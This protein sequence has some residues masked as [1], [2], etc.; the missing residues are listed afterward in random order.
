MGLHTQTNCPISTIDINVRDATH[1]INFRD[2]PITVAKVDHGG[3]FHLILPYTLFNEFEFGFRPDDQN[4]Y[5]NFYFDTHDNKIN[6]NAIAGIN[7]IVCGTY[8]CTEENAS[9]SC[10][11]TSNIKKVTAF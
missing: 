9:D 2:V 4:K 10:N 8:V 5:G 6:Y 7:D 1:E 3:L 11:I